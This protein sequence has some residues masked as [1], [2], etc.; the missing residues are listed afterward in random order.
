M[1]N[2]TLPTISDTW[3]NLIAFLKNRDTDLALGLD[4]ATTAP[5]NVPTNAIRWNSANAFWEKFNG[6]SWAALTGT[7]AISISGLAGSVAFANVTGKPTTLGG[8]GITDAQ[9]L[10]ADLT[11]IAAFTGTGLAVRTTTN[12]W[13]Q[14]SLAAPA[15]GFTITNPAGVAGN[16]TFVL[17]NDLAAVEGL[18]TTGGVERTG[19]D[20][21]ATYT[22]TAYG[23]TLVAVADAT[24]G[25]TALAAAGVGVVN[26]WTAQQRFATQTLTD[27]A[28]ISWNLDTQQVAKVTLGGNRTLDNPTNM[29]DGGNYTLRVIQDGTGGRTLA[30][31]SAYKWEDGT[32]PELASGIGAITILSF[33][34]DGTNMYG[35]TFTR[36]PS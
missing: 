6:T 11:A 7:Y 24:A 30:F 15:A 20:A 8:Y 13:A 22:L 19:A 5:T 25:R 23:K 9:P 14:R 31:G 27:G 33:H 26:S 17:A 12:T 1:A 2:W 3:A 21:W 35:A 10:D 4:P 36:N 16:P 29:R 34:S 28:N 32:P 18:A